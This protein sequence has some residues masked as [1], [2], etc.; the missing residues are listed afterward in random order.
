M[1]SYC[2]G[3][4]IDEELLGKA[5]ALR[6]LINYRTKDSHDN[7][8]NNK[9]DELSSNSTKFWRKLNVLL[10]KSSNIKPEISLKHHVTGEDV[11]GKAVPEYINTFFSQIGPNL[12]HGLGSQPVVSNDKQ[13]TSNSHN[14]DPSMQVSYREVLDLVKVI[15]LH[16]SSGLDSIQGRRP[17]VIHPMKN[18]ATVTC[19][20]RSCI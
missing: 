12:F 15:E 13:P 18:N 4:K 5:K 9:L 17:S 10:G 3:G 11:R 7:Y 2:R 6:D 19:S 16:K 1:L 14:L 8:M 20:V